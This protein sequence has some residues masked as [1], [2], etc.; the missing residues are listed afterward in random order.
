VVTSLPAGEFV[1]RLYEKG[2]YVLPSGTDGV[3]AIPYLNITK[4]QVQE[5]IGIIASV[6]EAYADKAARRRDRWHEAARDIRSSVRRQRSISRRHDIASTLLWRAR[7][8]FGIGLMNAGCW[9]HAV[10]DPVDSPVRQG[11]RS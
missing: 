3:R 8:T 2:L 5:A 11:S 1:E 4:A 6:A 7:L 9:S 10:H